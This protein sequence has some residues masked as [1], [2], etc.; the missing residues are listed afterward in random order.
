MEKICGRIRNVNQEERT[1]EIVKK[2]K[3]EFF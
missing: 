2:R 1:F 3:V